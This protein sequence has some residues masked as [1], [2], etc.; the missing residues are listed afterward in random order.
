MCLSPPW[1]VTRAGM[2]GGTAKHRPLLFD[3]EQRGTLKA[4]GATIT[5]A[6]DAER[7]AQ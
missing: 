4:V 3:R 1:A 7:L 2:A 5:V 6:T